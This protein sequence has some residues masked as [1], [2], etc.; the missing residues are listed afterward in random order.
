MA[1]QIDGMH[2]VVG[3][4]KEVEVGLAGWL[5]LEGSGQPTRK[6][7]AVGRQVAKLAAVAHLVHSSDGFHIYKG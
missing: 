4:H 3:L 5:E 2:A 1:R 7:L 6:Q